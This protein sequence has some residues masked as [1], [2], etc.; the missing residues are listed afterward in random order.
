M[1]RALLDADD[2]LMEDDDVMIAS[3]ARSMEVRGVVAVERDIL[4]VVV[5]AVVW[6]RFDVV[7]WWV[8]SEGR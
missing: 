3:F 1:P 5:V 8:A 4:A 6:S 2:V 7:W